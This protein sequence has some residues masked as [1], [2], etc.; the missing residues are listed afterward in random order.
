MASNLNGLP[1][2]QW[3][4]RGKPMLATGTRSEPTGRKRGHG[5]G[6]RGFHQL[7]ASADTAP[8]QHQTDRAILPVLGAWLKTVEPFSHNLACFWEVIALDAIAIPVASA[9]GFHFHK[10]DRR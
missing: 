8:E 2:L 9:P 5:I 1:H 6:A 7:A 10:G 4:A 3:A